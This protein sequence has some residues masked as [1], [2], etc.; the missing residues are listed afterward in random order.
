[1]YLLHFLVVAILE[2]QVD[3]DRSTKSGHSLEQLLSENLIFS[4]YSW[5]LGVIIITFY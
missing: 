1:M 2:N 5:N 3:R 4:N